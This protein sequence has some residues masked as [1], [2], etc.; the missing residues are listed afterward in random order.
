MPA[1]ECFPLNASYFFLR[2]KDNNDKSLCYA[3]S[4]WE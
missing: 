1:R 4:A 2:S 3:F